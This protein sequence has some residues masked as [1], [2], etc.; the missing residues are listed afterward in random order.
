MTC[1][2]LKTT[3]FK[4]P[5]IPLASMFLDHMMAKTR[6]RGRKS[7]WS[8]LK[9]CL[10][11]GFA[12]NHPFT[13]QPCQRT[14]GSCCQRTSSEAPSLLS[15]T[16]PISPSTNS[17]SW[18]SAGWLRESGRN[19]NTSALLRRRIRRIWFHPAL[20]VNT[21]V[22]EYLNSNHI[23]TRKFSTQRWEDTGHEQ[24]FLKL[25]YEW[26]N[27]VIQLMERQHLQ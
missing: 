22:V 7:K 27:T 3:T 9:T 21:C 14:G 18:A 20:M 23:W 12:D 15:F 17:P 19:I 26:L 10:Q 6:Q 11:W 16:I 8:F 24:I 4:M 13:S 5:C 2:A 25:T 1:I